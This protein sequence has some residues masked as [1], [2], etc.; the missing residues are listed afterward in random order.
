VAE[1]DDGNQR[2]DRLLKLHRSPLNVAGFALVLFLLVWDTGRTVSEYD[3]GRHR[4]LDWIAL[5]FIAYGVVAVLVLFPRFLAPR[6]FRGATDPER[7]S[8]VASNI[9]LA[10]AAAPFVGSLSL[11]GFGADQW[12]ANVALVVSALLLIPYVLG[13]RSTVTS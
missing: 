5:T 7:T 6:A 2:G 9:R 11:V 3:Q 13:A 8:L 10:M 12:V 1:Q 4:W